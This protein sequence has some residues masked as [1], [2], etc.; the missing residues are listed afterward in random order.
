MI[1]VVQVAVCFH[2]N[3]KHIHTVCGGQNVQ[4]LNVKLLVYH[5]T[6]RA[7]KG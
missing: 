3:T 1:Y 4:L 7:L 6:S 2:I 5:V